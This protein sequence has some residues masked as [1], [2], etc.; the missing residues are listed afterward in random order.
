MITKCIRMSRH[1]QDYRGRNPFQRSLRSQPPE[2]AHRRGHCLQEDR[3]VTHAKPSAHLFKRRDRQR[4][5][6]HNVRQGFPTCSKNISL[7]KVIY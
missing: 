5:G 4:L 2:L 3:Q 6:G 1:W 7:H